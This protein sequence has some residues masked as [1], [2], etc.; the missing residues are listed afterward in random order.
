M[1]LKKSRSGNGGAKVTFEL[2]ATVA[3]QDA[4]LC[5]D[6]NDWSTTATPLTRRR[7][8]RF[9]TTLHLE[10]GRAYRFRYLLDGERWENDWAADGYEA[11][12]YGE[13]D[14]IVRT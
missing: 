9:T 6:F 1:A 8:G 12:P 3:P 11:N 14:S 10:A 7:D 5:G 13:D 2:P 4:H